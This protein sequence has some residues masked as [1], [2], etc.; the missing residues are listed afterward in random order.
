MKSAPGKPGAV[1]VSEMDP[2]AALNNLKATT[3]TRGTSSLESSVG[4]V[5]SVGF[6]TANSHVMVVYVDE[7]CANRAFKDAL[8]F[9]KLSV[10]FNNVQK[11]CVC[12]IT[13]FYIRFQVPSIKLLDQF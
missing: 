3:R 9:S 1:L 10:H 2:Q 5:G 4:S 13:S 7:D 11:D 12:R 8:G 6:Q